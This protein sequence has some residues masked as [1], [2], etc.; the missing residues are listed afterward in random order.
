MQQD[1]FFEK[2]TLN[3]IKAVSHPGGPLMIVAGPGSGKTLVMAHRIAWLVLKEDVRP[4][5]ILGMTF[6]N[7]AANELRERCESL[8]QNTS[9]N[10][11]GFQVY[12]F[13]SLCARI[14]R[15]H[16][17]AAGI[18][19][20]FSIYDEN[21]QLRTIKTVMDAMEINRKEHPPRRI[22][23]LV[24]RAKNQKLTPADVFQRAENWIDEIN[25]RVYE[26][27]EEALSR[28]NAV[29]FDDLLLKTLLMLEGN[30]SVQADW[31]NRFEHVLIDEFQ[32]TNSLQFKLGEILSNPQRN[33]C[34]V[35]DPD[36]S[37]YSWR[38][39]DPENIDNFLATYSDCTVVTL[40]ESFR[41]TQNI[42]DA[43]NAVILPNQNRI[44]KN[45]WTHKKEGLPVS[46]MESYDPE[47]EANNVIREVSRLTKR[48]VESLNETAV[49]YRSNVQSRVLEH[50]CRYWGVP[51]K[52]IGG[53]SFYMRETV[54]DLA[55]YMRV[56]LNP[57]DDGALE[58]IINKPSRSI[59]TKTLA[60]LRRAAD[61]NDA[62][63][64]DSVL[65]MAEEGN[66]MDVRLSARGTKAVA[67]FAEH[68]K[69]IIT[70]STTM[71]PD[72]LLKLIIH[73]MDY[74]RQM[75][76]DPETSSDK[77]DHAQELLVLAERHKADDPRE[78]LDE[79]LQNISLVSSADYTENELNKNI[80]TLTLITLHQAKG[81]EFDT[82]FIAGMT[83][84]LLPHSRSLEENGL[85]EER[86]LCYV[87]MTRARRRLYLSYTGSYR[88][89]PV[90][91]S[92]FLS[93]LP[94]NLINTHPRIMTHRHNRA[95]PA[96]YSSFHD[97]D[98]DVEDTHYEEKQ[99][100]SPK[101]STILV[102]G[103]KIIHEFFGAGMVVTVDYDKLEPEVTIVFKDKSAGIKRFLIAM[104]PITKTTS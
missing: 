89:Q 11:T 46:V 103:D 33:I 59:G 87:G 65:S 1:K 5:R 25:A 101:P 98:D 47:E 28:A 93:A 20:R 2:L 43:A 38:Y 75:D 94:E 39:A 84:G 76:S 15:F 80:E 31:Q 85:E 64:L 63:L 96:R 42:L 102:A 67:N 97:Y 7:K 92:Q 22:L 36:Q 83:E 41:S 79:F 54:R 21:E 14:L 88:N 24:S 60:E 95:Y 53:V 82:V 50:A 61:R 13:H 58:R 73:S 77:R 55:S 34:V 30:P 81:L 37:I 44:E 68:M 18:R 52:V 91:P 26:R 70:A 10:A 17:E 19:E 29:D 56:V 32:D 49:L 78:A 90:L 99:R 66:P 62:Y 72:K 69:K 74:E 8:V 16:P 23:S 100:N 27:Y 12:T 104:A 71:Q 4:W 51:Y 48:N 9:V 57:N 35:G 3:Q 86:R 45:L 6:T 40:D